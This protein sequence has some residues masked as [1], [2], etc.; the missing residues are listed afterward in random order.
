MVAQFGANWSTRSDLYWGVYGA[1]Y[2]N[3]VAINGDP[4]NTLYATKAE[5]TLGVPTTGAP[6][7]SNSTQAIP[8][9]KID[10]LGNTY[11]TPNI[12]NVTTSTNSP[13]AS[14]QK[15]TLP[16]SF[17]TYVTGS[18]GSVNSA[19]NYFSNSMG[20]FAGGADNT[21]LDLFRITNSTN[22]GG[23]FGAPGSYEGTFSISSGGQVSFT[24]V[25]EPATIYVSLMLLGLVAW[26]KRRSLAGL[27]KVEA[28]N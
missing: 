27:L 6:V 8:A 4:K 11:A 2:D 5:T 28:Q 21:K 1:T 3:D 17:A 25:P 19:F 12:G 9:S 24:A 15:T 14:I 16:G 10:T 18:N 13:L 7:A 23:V 20:N 22:G 26:H